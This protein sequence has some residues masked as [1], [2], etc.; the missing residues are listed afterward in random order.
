MSLFQNKYRIEP[1]RLKSWD[2]SKSWY[3]YVTINTKNHIRYFGKVINNKMVLN[4]IGKIV[5]KEW[6]KSGELRNNIELDYYVVMPNHLH[7]IIIIDSGVRKD[8]PLDRLK[9]TLQRS[10]STTLLPNSLGS[11]IGQ[12]KSMCT[13]QIHEKGYNNFAWQARFYDRIIRNEKELY[14]IRNYIQQNLL[15]WELNGGSSENLDI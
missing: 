14:K 6:L 8:D 10:V 5:D 9:E 1:A 4:E 11:V 2:Y 3:Y 15:R 12:F 7:G 13:K